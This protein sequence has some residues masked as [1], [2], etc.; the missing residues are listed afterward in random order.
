MADNQS[1]LDNERQGTPRRPF[2]SN[3][4]ATVSTRLKLRREIMQMIIFNVT[5]LAFMAIHLTIFTWQNG[6]PVHEIIPQNLSTALANI[7]AILAEISLLGGLG[8][9]YEQI[10]RTV[11]KRRPVFGLEE[12]LRSLNSN[13][14]NLV[15]PKVIVSI[16]KIREL[17]LVSLLCAGIP[18]AI[19]FPPGAL[20]VEFENAVS[21]TL[22]NVPTMNI[23]DYGNGTPK[24]FV[25]KSL[26]EMD[27]SF[28]YL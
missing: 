8:I 26:F 19:V 24:S 15:R 21:T 3:I 16:I 28:S 23:S 14:W 20:T 10:L 6:K 2:P 9:A 11:W 12:T 27:G 18:F 1:L 13:P 7:L 22:R 4:P 25:E 17:W 5:S